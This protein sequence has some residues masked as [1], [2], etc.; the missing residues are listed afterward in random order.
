MVTSINV[1]RALVLPPI[2]SRLVACKKI[3]SRS[4]A[5]KHYET[6]Q[7]TNHVCSANVLV[8]LAVMV[9]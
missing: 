5:H 1:D 6:G 4:M 7:V 9:A 8:H 3:L 2:L